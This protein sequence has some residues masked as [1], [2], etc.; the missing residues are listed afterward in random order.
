MVN[1]LEGNG[2]PENPSRVVHWIFD[3][4][5]H[6]GAFGGLVGKIDNYQNQANSDKQSGQTPTKENT[7]GEKFV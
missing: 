6:G 4:D 5:Q 2:T 3:L 1:T 7:Y